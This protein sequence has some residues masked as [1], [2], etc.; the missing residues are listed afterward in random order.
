MVAI[1]T[2]PDSVALPQRARPQPVAVDA[3]C[4][5]EGVLE[6]GLSFGQHMLALAAAVVLAGAL[7]LA[8]LAPTAGD[9]A[10]ISSSGVGT[11]THYVEP[12]DSIWSIATAVAPAGEVAAYAER[13]IERNGTATPI[14]GSVLVIP[15]P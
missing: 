7:L 13:L 8:N 1:A 9:G 2:I 5:S 4:G 15:A 12:G 6:A 3:N 14:V 10:T 11:R